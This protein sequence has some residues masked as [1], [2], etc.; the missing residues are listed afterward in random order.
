[1]VSFDFRTLALACFLVAPGIT[2]CGEDHDDH[3][4][5]E[6]EVVFAEF[7]EHLAEG[8]EIAVTASADAAAAPAADAEHTRYDITLVDD[9]NGMFVGSIT[10][11]IDAEDQIVALTEAIPYTV[12]GSDG[13]EVAIHE[14]LGAPSECT[15]IASARHFEMPIG[16]VTLTFGPTDVQTF[17]MAVEASDHGADEHE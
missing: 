2:A 3:D 11:A 12:F 6:E 5:G 8:P 16:T 15:L 1:M 10:R 13:T 14:D 7:C 4:H 9:G 17:S